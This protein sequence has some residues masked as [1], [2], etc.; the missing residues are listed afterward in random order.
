MSQNCEKG[1][2][3]PIN[4]SKIICPAGYYCPGSASGSASA[5]KCKT[6]TY[7]P[8]GSSV[9]QQCPNGYLCYS[10]DQKINIQVLLLLARKNGIEITLSGTGSL[11][12]SAGDYHRLQNWA[13]Q[14]HYLIQ[15]S[16]FNV[17]F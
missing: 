4:G 15:S 7:C 12:I 6:G 5:Y 9:E 13:M 14:N 1:Y 2:Y 11:L 16:I 8:Q 10:P 17:S 3:C